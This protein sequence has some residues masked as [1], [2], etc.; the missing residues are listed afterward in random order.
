MINYFMQNLYISASIFGSYPFK[1]K[2]HRI[3]KNIIKLH[4]GSTISSFFSNDKERNTLQNKIKISSKVHS[5]SSCGRLN[6]FSKKM[7]T[8][9]A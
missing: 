5:F 2:S 7:H 4:A 3:A 1:K 9:Y 6:T 8:Q